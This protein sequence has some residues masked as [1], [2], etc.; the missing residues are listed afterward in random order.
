M[1]KQCEIN[2]EMNKGRDIKIGAFLH[3]FVIRTSIKNRQVVSNAML[4]VGFICL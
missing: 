2:Y 1:R 4:P 3:L